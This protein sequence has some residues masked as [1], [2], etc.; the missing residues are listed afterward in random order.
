[1][2]LSPAEHAG[3]AHGPPKPFYPDEATLALAPPGQRAIKEVLTEVPV[4]GRT[5]LHLGT[6]VSA[7]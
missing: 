6:A 4:I 1:M 2:E 3:L 5:I 7:Q